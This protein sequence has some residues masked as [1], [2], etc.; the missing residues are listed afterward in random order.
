MPDTPDILTGP[1]LVGQLDL[2]APGPL[3]AGLADLSTTLVRAS[4]SA[5][6]H[7]AGAPDRALAPSGPVDPGAVRAWLTSTYDFE[8]PQPV[9][10]VIADT[11]EQL[12]RWTVHTT[13]PRYFGLFNPTPTAA[14][15]AGELLAAA[16]NPQLAAWSHAPAAAEIEQHVL[17][18]IAD[19]LGLSHGTAAGNVTSGGAEA[20]LTAVL[21]ALTRA[22]PEYASRGLRGLDAQPVFYASAESHLAWVKIAHATGLGREALRLVEVDERLQLDT[23]RLAELIAADLAAGYRPFLV[24]GTAG[25]TGAGALDPLPDIAALAATHDLWFHADAAWAG[26]VALSDRLRPLLIGVERAHSVTVDAHKW[27]SV[28]MGAGMIVTRDPDALAQAFGLSTAFM[29]A[30]VEDAADPYATSMQS[31]RRF[32]GL[33]IFLTLTTAGRAAYAAQLERD[34]ALGQLLAQRLTAA[35]FEVVNDTPLPVVCFTLPDAAGRSPEDAWAWHARVAE[36]VIATGG[37]WI[38]ALRLGGRPALRACI[39]SYR[40]KGGD[41]DQLIAALASAVRSRN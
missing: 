41:V 26:A 18:F 36:R 28:P 40:T 32:A 16:V 25:T 38:T 39:T 27:L 11:L 23:S 2:D 24:I 29:P 15:I 7:L 33:K 22:F 9:D 17:R 37:G 3:E 31:S 35:G 12:Q 21:M 6:D 5:V 19:R 20:N 10:A 14:G 13:H 4:A 34:V 30:E 1:G 8:Q